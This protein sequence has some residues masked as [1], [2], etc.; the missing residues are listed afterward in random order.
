MAVLT[1]D[2]KF[3]GSA[4][5]P[6][7]DIASPGGAID[8][9]TKVTFT[10][11]ANTTGLVMSTNGLADE[12][13][14]DVT[15]RNAGGSIVSDKFTMF[16]TLAIQTGSS[17]TAFE[18]I[19]RMAVSS[20]SH[21]GTITITQDDSPTWTAIGTMENG[22]D[23]IYR[24]FYRASS[25]SANA[26][27]YFEK[28]FVKNNSVTNNLLSAYV[29]ESGEVGFSSKISF[30]LCSSGNDNGAS[31]NNR[32]GPPPGTQLLSAQ[33]GTGFDSAAKAV[34]SGDLILGENQ[35]IWLKLDLAAGTAGDKG[36][37]NVTVSG[38]TT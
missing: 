18:R 24:P 20:G 9:T 16:Q 7:G 36:S 27:E 4:S 38:E 30:D 10:D 13:Q 14:V 22:V 1:S 3:Y 15:G 6:T 37:W 21:T 28:I 34:V 35:G 5:M 17:A 32:L 25:A 33:T 19:L 31:S 29:A 11:M 12:V 26:K 23:K 8:T 2:I